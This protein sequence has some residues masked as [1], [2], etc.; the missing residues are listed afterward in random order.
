MT[1]KK[2]FI[3][4]HRETAHYSCL[5]F[6]PIF[7]PIAKGC[8]RKHIK[9]NELKR[10]KLENISYNG[11]QLDINLDFKL[12]SLIASRVQQ[13]Q[14]TKISF[15]ERQLIVLGLKRKLESQLKQ[16]VENRLG[17]LQ[18]A[19][20]QINRFDE[21]SNKLTGRYTSLIKSFDWNYRKKQINIEVDEDLA[22]LSVSYYSKEK[23]YIDIVNQL[24]TDHEKALF[25]YLETRKFKG[26][27]KGVNHN[28]DYLISR[29]A[30]NYKSKN[31]Q[32]KAL[33][34]AIKSLSTIGYINTY[35]LNKTE[36]EESEYFTILVNHD[37][38]D[39]N[40]VRDSLCDH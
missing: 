27:K 25:L 14:S 3:N 9:I 29:V 35:S 28:F 17:A 18:K 22:N 21:H 31:D 36:M 37:F 40:R 38:V 6:A 15:T 1:E 39:T 11:E 23:I 33:L 19:Q 7:M 2:L 8:A 12:Y 5:L 30:P 32:R 24:R 34:K 20:F 10:T 4:N 13:Q 16:K 26:N